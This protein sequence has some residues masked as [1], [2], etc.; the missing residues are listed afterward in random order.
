MSKDKLIKNVSLVPKIILTLYLIVGL[1]PKVVE[2]EYEGFQWLYFSILNILSLI[3]IYSKK[4]IL[5]P[6]SISKKVNQ[7]FLLFLLFLFFAIISIFQ[8]RIASESLVHIARLVNIIVGTYTIFTLVKSNPKD[9]LQFI[10]KLCLVLLAY[11][12]FI[13]LGHY[14]GNYNKPRNVQLFRSFLHYYGNINIFT[15]SLVVKLPLAIY[16]FTSSKNIIWKY[17]SGIIIFTTI[18]ALFFAGSRTALLSMVMVFIGTI[19]YLLIEFIKTPNKKSKMPNLIYLALVPFLALFLVLNVN[20]VDKSKMNSLS[21]IL[22]YSNDSSKEVNRFLEKNKEILKSSVVIEKEELN[23]FEKLIVKSGRND[24][25]RS[26]LMIFSKNSLLGIGYGN[27]KIYPL[28]EYFSKKKSVGGK[29]GKPIRV[30]NDFFE[31]FIE[32]GIIGGTLYVLLFVFIF[33]MVL[34]LVKTKFKHEIVFLFFVGLGYSLDA[35]F[36][37]PIERIPVQLFF[38]IVAAFILAFNYVVNKEK[39]IKSSFLKALYFPIILVTIVT[40]FSNYLVF[41]AYIVNTIIKNEKVFKKRGDYSFTFK[42]MD[43][44]IKDYPTLDQDGIKMKYYLATYAAKEKK[45]QEAIDILT[46][47]STNST[48]DFL[49]NK[50]KGEIFLKGLKN[51]DSSEFYFKKVFNIY[52]SYKFNYTMLKNI[53]KGKN[54]TLNLEKTQN[55]YLKFNNVDYK[56]WIEKAEYHYK[57]ENNISLGI[58]ILDTALVY[59]NRS[60]DILKAKKKLLDHKKVNTYIK[61]NKTKELYDQVIGF[62]TKGKFLEAK[63]LLTQM[64]KD[65]PDDHF[66][67]FYIGIMELSLK[68]YKSGITFLTEA[69]NLNIFKDGKAEYCRALCYEALGKKVEA[70]ADYRAARA[71]K[72]PQAMS[73]PASKYK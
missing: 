38:I 12:S 41:K 36:N 31:K 34:F 47:E 6:Y 25:W 7:F 8:A 22:T 9:F 64:L 52:P 13:T 53:Y 15:A 69:I 43:R 51:L 62:Y 11:H 17:I 63:K 5:L 37:F 59:N 70:K 2:I 21:Q 50:Q 58:S 44:L 56:E 1:S 68:N 18:L 40:V 67:I 3:Y 57:K 39:A 4:E 73:L 49:L 45:Y 72:F 24:I 14:L 23:D 46:E 60:L 10:S 16:L 27:Y 32:T 35:F 28:E 66:A 55:E 30:H 61:A 33:I 54:D 48:Y 26:A 19:I 65:K 71:K 29:F 20:R 42:E